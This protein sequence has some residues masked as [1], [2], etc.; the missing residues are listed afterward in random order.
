MG[1]NPRLS[2][3]VS[4]CVPKLLLACCNATT[5][6]LR[7]YYLPVG[8]LLLACCKATTCLFSEATTCVLRGCSCVWRSYFP[9]AE[10]AHPCLIDQPIIITFDL[11]DLVTTQTFARSYYPLVPEPPQ[12]CPHCVVL[13]HACLHACAHVKQK[14]DNTRIRDLSTSPSNVT[15][16]LDMQELQFPPCFVPVGY[17]S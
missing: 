9:V 3:C 14:E 7:S 13:G 15:I 17:A 11:L 16:L 1:S 6:L 12:C 4:E 8:K 10:T 2:E 5:Y